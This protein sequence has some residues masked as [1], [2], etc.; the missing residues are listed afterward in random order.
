M[1]MN[2]YVGRELARERQ[3]ECW[4][5]PNAS[6]WSGGCMPSPGQPSPT[7]GPGTAF[8]APC[9][10]LPGCAHYPEPD[11]GRARPRCPAE[12][13]RKAQTD[14]T[15]THR[16]KLIILTTALASGSLAVSM[17]ATPRTRLRPTRQ[18]P[19]PP[20]LRRIHADHGARRNPGNQRTTVRPCAP[21]G[22][23]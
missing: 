22:T 19:C 20:S 5:M 13:P 8:A 23:Q 18:P 9:A 2:P 10:Q 15:S 1:F 21:G 12:Q 7:N 14:E 11:S 4:R 17:I 6:A 3:R 16:G